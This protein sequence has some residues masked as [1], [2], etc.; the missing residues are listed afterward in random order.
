[1]LPKNQKVINLLLIDVENIEVEIL[2]GGDKILDRTKAIIIEVRNNTEKLSKEILYK[3]VFKIK[4]SDKNEYS[5]N[6][7]GWR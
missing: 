7:F 5:K 1:M 2:K 3:H 4:E 6:I